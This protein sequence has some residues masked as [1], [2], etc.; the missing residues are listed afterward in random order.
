MVA[1]RWLNVSLHDGSGGGFQLVS[2]TAIETGDTDLIMTREQFD[3]LDQHM[4]RRLAGAANT[5]EITGKST[6][7]EVRSY[8]VRQRSLTEYGDE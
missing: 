7:L 1:W 5:D 8:C 3:R 6:L 4:K 2:E